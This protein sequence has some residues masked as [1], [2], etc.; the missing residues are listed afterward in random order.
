MPD[1]GMRNYKLLT[2]CVLCAGGSDAPVELVDPLLGIHAAVTRRAPGESQASWN[3]KEKISMLDAVKLFTIG[4][5]FATNEENLKGTITRGKLADMTV[6]SNNLFTMGSPDDL[7]K[8][9]IEM[10]II[11]GE[12]K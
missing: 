10:T 1:M 9:K 3:Q 7:L 11:D 8:T 2:S 6:F 5:A 12:I 4:G